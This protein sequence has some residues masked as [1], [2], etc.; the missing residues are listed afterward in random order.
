[1]LSHQAYWLRQAL[2]FWMAW[3]VKLNQLKKE[4]E[5]E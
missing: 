1:M 5:N 2:W 4:N 3:I